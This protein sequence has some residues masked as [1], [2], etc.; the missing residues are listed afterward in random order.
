[1][2]SEPNPKLTD[3]V[4]ASLR[5]LILSNVVHPGQKLVD[6]DLAEQLGVSRTPIR[7]AL[8]RLAMVGLV[9][10]RGRRGFYVND[11]SAKE[12]SDLYVLRQVLEVHATRL[13]AENADEGHLRELD[14]ILAESQELTKQPRKQVAAIRLDLAIHEL[15]ARASGNAALHRAIRDLLDKVMCVMWMDDVAMDVK[16]IEENHREH[17]TLL[18][19]LRNRDADAAAALVHRHIE[20]AKQRLERVCQ[21]RDDLQAD[22]LASRAPSLRGR[23]G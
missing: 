4:Y 17:Q 10:A 1:M 19:L 23:A 11:F 5:D 9:A 18:R 6:R 12:V 20:Q 15:I 13:A 14:R 21:A 3:D 16:A 22:V 2:T 8:N 7:E